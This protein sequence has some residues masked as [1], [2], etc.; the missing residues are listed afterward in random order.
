MTTEDYNKDNYH[1]IIRQM[2][3]S[4]DEVR[5][6]RT[7]WFLI[8]QG[9]LIAGF[10][11]LC[12]KCNLG[13]LILLISILG[14][15]VSVS[16]GYAA[17]RSTKAV[18]MAIAC[19]KLYLEEH[20]K[21]QSEYPPINLITKEIISHKVD[22]AEIQIAS[23][24]WNKNIYDKMYEGKS[25]FIDRKI[26]GLEFLLPYQFLPFAFFTFW[27]IE[28]IALCYFEGWSVLLQKIC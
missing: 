17:W 6:Q 7:N 10:C 15:I 25:S 23:L 21:K 8:I 5:N 24:K 2:I 12:E 13:V 3:K 14:L 4:E 1:N 28:V 19:W 11:S 9:F 22:V 16:F 18:T 27:M 20:D 26:N